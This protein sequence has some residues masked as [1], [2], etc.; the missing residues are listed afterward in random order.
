MKRLMVE[1]TLAEGI[2]VALGGMAGAL[3][4]DCLVDNALE[5]PFKK[6]GKLYLGFIGAAVVGAFIGYVIDG[7]LVTAMMAG[8]TGKGVLEQLL[9][10]PISK[11]DVV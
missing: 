10:K 7:S 3:A 6:E 11:E 8:Y 2:T 5:L 9:K 4:K 1:L